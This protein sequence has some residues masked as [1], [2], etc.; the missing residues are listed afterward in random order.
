MNIRISKYLSSAGICSRRDAEKLIVEKKIKI[1]NQLCVH[2]SHKVSNLDIIKV[3]K[4]NKILPFNYKIPSDISSSAF[5]IVLTA[6]SKSSE[7]TIKN[8]N[9]NPSRTGIITILKKMGVKISFKN[10]KIY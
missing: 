10:K 1:N 9:I 5:F 2:P 6:L 4:A 7:L 8:V 3:R